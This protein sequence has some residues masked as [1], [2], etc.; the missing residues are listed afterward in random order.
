M[1]HLDLIPERLHKEVKALIN[2]L[3]LNMINI[4]LLI[5]YIPQLAAAI[6]CP[7]CLS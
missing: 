5:N 6:T 1:C 4:S 2:A 7:N 3:I